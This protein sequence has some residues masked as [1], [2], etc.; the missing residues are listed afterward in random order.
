MD[1]NRPLET[2]QK[3]QRFAG[4]Q[5]PPNPRS[6]GHRRAYSESFR[7]TEEFLFDSDPD[8]NFS[9]IDFPSLSDENKFGST[10]TAAAIPIPTDSGG[11]SKPLAVNPV[12]RPSVGGAHL[13]SLSLDTAF[14]D[15]LGFQ[16]PGATSGS[17]Q[18][19]KP[20]HRHSSSMDG[21]TSPFEGE[22]VPPSSDFSKAAMTADKLAELA[23]I[24]PK[25]AK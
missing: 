16:A 14:F 15:G 10:T 13:R 22:S 18:E 17:A 20:Q 6:S 7:L 5:I 24:D 19:K 1:S 3:N 4:G 21:S 2:L 23:L 12:S 11:T 25:R 9:D 8:F